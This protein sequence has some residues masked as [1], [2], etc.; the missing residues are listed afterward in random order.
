MWPQHILLW[1]ELNKV[2]EGATKEERP[3]DPALQQ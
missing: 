1:V 3:F 2:S